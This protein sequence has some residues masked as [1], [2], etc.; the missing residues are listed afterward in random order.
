MPKGVYPRPQPL[1][2][3]CDNCGKTFLRHRGE[4]D[5]GSVT[6]FCS[7]ACRAQY[8]DAPRR[9]EKQHIPEPNSGCWLW[10][11]AVDG[12]GYGV[13]WMN[14]KN[15]T[16]HRAAYEI[17]LQKPQSSLAVCH[18]CDNRLCVNPD[19]LFLGTPAENSADMVAKN[20]QSKG[21][22]RHNSK[23]NPEMVRII[24]ASPMSDKKLAAT[25]GVNPAAIY[26]VRQ[27]RNWRHVKV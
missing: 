12:G 22:R 15:L 24:L 1:S 23:L 8:N 9:F 11:G 5:R 2:I 25:L 7:I 10:T 6:T 3:V 14:G 17:F 13:F 16:A 18:R 20:R 4:I 21:E 27:R 19:H 26:L